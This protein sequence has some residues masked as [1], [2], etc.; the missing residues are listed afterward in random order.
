[1]DDREGLLVLVSKNIILLFLIRQIGFNLL[2]F[3]YYLFADLFI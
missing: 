1:M 2:Q 3:I